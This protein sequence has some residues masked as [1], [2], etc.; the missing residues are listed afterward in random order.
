MKLR[1]E[2]GKDYLS[3]RNHNQQD[4]DD[5]KE[6]RRELLRML[7]RIESGLDDVKK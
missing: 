5:L 7:R 6:I 4:I 1:S 2:D 3:F